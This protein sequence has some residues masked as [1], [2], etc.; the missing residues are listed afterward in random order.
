MIILTLIEATSLLH[1]YGI[2]CDQ[3]RVKQWIDSGLIKGKALK[4]DYKIEDEA[5]YDFLHSYQWEGTSYE[6]GIDDKTKI[7]RL[8]VE[9]EDLKAQVSKL[10][11][12]KEKLEDQLG[13]LPF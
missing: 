6:I 10:T 4:S 9:I 5:I 11:R 8:L 12:D 2:K 7:K 13:I 1:S 3:K